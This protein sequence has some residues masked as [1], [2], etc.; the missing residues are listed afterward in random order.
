MSEL[1]SRSVVAAVVRRGANFLLCKRPA[2]KRHGGLWEFPGGKVE[3]SETFLEAITRE[4]EEELGVTVCAVERELFQ[5]EDPGS[6]FVIHF[7]EV[8][9]EGEPV[10]REHEAVEWLS[11]E[12]IRSIP[13]APSD[14]AF[15]S[16]W[17]G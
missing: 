1:R 9:I 7:I 17:N 6:M 13:L 11:L 4:L 10:A 2:H 14:H 8:S 5:A 16:Q 12:A 3:E 15:V